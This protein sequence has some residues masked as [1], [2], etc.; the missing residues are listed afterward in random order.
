M[1]GDAHPVGDGV[2][3]MRFHFGSGYRVYFAQKRNR[4]ILLL[5]GGDKSSQKQDILHAIGILDELKEA[6]RW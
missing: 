3:E 5:V 6:G 4:V 2:N 1:V